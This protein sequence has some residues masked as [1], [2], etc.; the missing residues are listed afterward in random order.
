MGSLPGAATWDSGNGRCSYSSTSHGGSPAG[1]VDGGSSPIPLMIYDQPCNDTSIKACGCWCSIRSI[2][3]WHIILLPSWCWLHLMVVICPRWVM[4]SRHKISLGF[5][6][7][8]FRCYLVAA[9]EVQV[10][11]IMAF[12]FFFFNGSRG[13]LGCPARVLSVPNFPNF[14][15]MVWKWSTMVL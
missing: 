10:R 12:V 1:E 8:Q 2:Y 15:W 3:R 14:A 4:I 9:P 5:F 7:L 11:K 13:S 6:H